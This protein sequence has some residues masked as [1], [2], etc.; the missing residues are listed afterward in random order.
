M[1]IVLVSIDPSDT[2]TLK[3][4]RVD[5]ARVDATTEQEIQAQIDE[6]EKEAMLD[7]GHYV[8]SIRVG[9]S[10]SQREFAQIINVSPQ[11]IRS[12]EQGK[13]FPRGT[14]TA[15]LRILFLEPEA[16]LS[17]LRRTVLSPPDKD[18]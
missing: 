6:D 15:L 4:A 12:W 17:A 3:Q 9:L 1:N 10:L 18:I 16:A 13:R 8:A 14:A 5:L 7:F 2:D 11:T